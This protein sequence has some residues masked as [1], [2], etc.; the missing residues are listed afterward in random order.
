MG[1][2]YNVAKLRTNAEAIISALPTTPTVKELMI[3]HKAAQG[4]N[5]SNQVTLETKI[6]AV[7]DAQTAATPDADVMMIALMIG[8]T[9]AQTLTTYVTQTVE[10]SNSVYPVPTGATK[11]F[12]SYGTGGGTGANAGGGSGGGGGGAWVGEFEIG[13]DGSGGGTLNIVKGGTTTVGDLILT[14][15]ANGAGGNGGA[16]GKVTYQGTPQPDSA[17]VINGGNGGSGGGSGGNAGVYLG[18]TPNSA[19]SGGGASYGGNGGNGLAAPVGVYGSGG[20]GGGW[21]GDPAL[22][23]ITLKFEIVTVA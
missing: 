14:S 1:T 10:S 3:A 8:S 13:V 23:G 5:C 4:L 19:Y 22:P 16:G 12:V 6:Q 2:S 18:G 11:C 21:V 9:Q 7:A 17:T 15:G 20:G